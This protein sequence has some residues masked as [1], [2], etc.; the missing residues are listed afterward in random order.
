MVFQM[1]PDTEAPSEMLIYFP[2]FRA[3]C[4]AEDATHNLHNLLTLRGAVVRDPHGWAKYL[5][6]AVDLFGDKTDVAFASHHWPTWGQERVVEFLG[7]QRD[8]YAYLHDQTLRLINKGWTGTEIAEHLPLPPALE[9][10]WSTHGYYG[11]V[12]HNLKAIYQRYMGWFDGNPAHLWQHTPV[13]QGKRYVEFMGGADEVVTKARG[14]F[15]G[16]DFRW[17]AEVLSHVVFAQPDHAAARSCSPTRSNNSATA[18]RTAP[19]ATSTSP[20]RPNCATGS[21]APRRSR[22]R[23]TSSRT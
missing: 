12:S 21:S 4:T 15:D 8:L 10:A 9:N 1:A 5:T 22:L 6:E 2:D 19:G 11:S 17:A 23:R 18:R 13:E 3:L 7:I 14:S 16:G 20:A